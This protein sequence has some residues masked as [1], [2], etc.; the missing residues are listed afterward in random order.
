MFNSDVTTTY[1]QQDATLEILIMLLGAFL[2]GFLFSW[3]LR[4]YL[5]SN[6]HDTAT[7]EVN[8]GNFHRVSSASDVLPQTN[9]SHT[10]KII[11]NPDDSIYTTPRMD[12]LTKISGLNNDVQ[13]HLKDHG[14]KSYTDLRDIEQKTLINTLN[15]CGTHAPSIKEA[16]T[17]PHQASLAAKGEWKKLGEYQAF[18]QRSR[19][20]SKVISKEA[21]TN[22]DDL[23]KIEGIG[24][25]I[26]EI[27]NKNGIYTYEDIRKADSDT[28]KQYLLTEDERFQRNETDTWPH[29]ASMAEK[30][31]WEELS[32]YQEFM[33]IN[34][35]ESSEPETL[36][37]PGSNN[38]I[39]L[40]TSAVQK[41]EI[42]EAQTKQ[43]E[44]STPSETSETVSTEPQKD[45]LRVI[46]GIG[47][48]LQELLNKHHIFTFADLSKTKPE[49]IQ[50]YLNDAGPQYSLHEPESWP[51]QAGMAAQGKWEELKKYQEVLIEE[52]AASSSH[53]TQEEQ[54][55]P[56]LHIKQ[57]HQEQDK[58]DDLKIIEGIGPKIELVLKESGIKNFE[59]LMNSNRNTLKSLLDAA[60]P[61]FRMHEPETWPLQAKMAFNKEW[62]KLREYQD[63]LMGGRE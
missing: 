51:H 17:W 53:E 47:P 10:A 32:I 13:K 2:L 38:I 16:E 62:E 4:K 60:G 54:N 22:K 12:D 3:L 9:A 15:A 43:I 55:K 50:Q 45:D 42:T 63:F 19:T 30:G 5:A 61:Q 26:E 18:I 21:P 31:Q 28:L 14:I 59:D 11:E 27:L 48:K 25:R 56:S 33:D 29:Q 35:D 37:E 24:P 58:E 52:N 6:S 1:N 46:E 23:K 8:E 36:T 7:N 44:V 40:P 41:S 39:D 34:N 20:S 57:V 49:E